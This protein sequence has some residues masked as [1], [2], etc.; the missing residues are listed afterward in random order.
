MDMGF[1]VRDSSY[2]NY[3][4]KVLITEVISAKDGDTPLISSLKSDAI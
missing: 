1:T 4:D 3:Q 2:K